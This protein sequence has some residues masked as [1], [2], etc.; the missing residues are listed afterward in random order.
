MKKLL[1]ISLFALSSANTGIA[2]S[3]A[4]VIAGKTLAVVGIAAGTM[5]YTLTGLTTLIAAT[6]SKHDQMIDGKKLAI[7]YGT[8]AALASATLAVATTKAAS[9]LL[10]KNMGDLLQSTIQTSA[11]CTAVLLGAGATALFGYLV[12]N[13]FTSQPDTRDQNNI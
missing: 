1:L 9:V 12:Y 3:D 4:T 2:S 11:I 13:S 8:C 7:A 5:A 10:Q 6:P